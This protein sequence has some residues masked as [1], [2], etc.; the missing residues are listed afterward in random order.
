MR[1]NVVLLPRHGGTSSREDVKCTGSSEDGT[2]SEDG[3]GGVRAE[4]ISELDLIQCLEIMNLI[5]YTV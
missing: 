4:L 1:V 2:S 5:K 3:G